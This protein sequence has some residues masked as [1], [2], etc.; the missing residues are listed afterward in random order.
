MKF[1]VRVPATSAN[2]GPGFD[3]LGIAWDIYADF[4]F[5]SRGR[6][7]LPIKK[8]PIYK[9]HEDLPHKIDRKN[10]VL[11]SYWHYGELMGIPLI[12]M[13]VYIDSNIPSTRGLGSSAAC[14]VA[15]AMAARQ[16]GLLLSEPSDRNIFT[17]ASILKAAAIL[18]GHPDNVAP[19][20]YG[21]LQLSRMEEE[22]IN[23][24]QLRVKK[25]LP[26]F[27]LI[28]DYSMSTAKSRGDL[29]DKLD[30]NDAVFN[31]ASLGFLIEG[32]RTGKE[33]YLKQGFRDRIHENYRKLAMKDFPQIKKI[34]MKNGALAIVL[35][36]SGSS[37]L[38]I[39]YKNRQDN[40][41]AGVKKEL[42]ANW[43]IRPVKVDYRGAHIL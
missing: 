19:A 43:S 36:G 16:V 20:L 21:G 13:G 35:S 42:P 1:T 29:P 24:I 10:L 6:A 30:R 38:C 2:M 41:E 40:F 9:S 39:S 11:K 26:F 25:D 14:I 17:D 22:N 12:D 23:A 32:L 4:R 27:V 37:I 33:K 28:P 8:L 3:C 18:E 5:H 34:A 31:L 15:G 7:D